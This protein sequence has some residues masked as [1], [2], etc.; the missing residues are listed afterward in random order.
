[1]NERYNIKGRLD[2]VFFVAK[3]GVSITFRE[4]IIEGWRILGGPEPTQEEINR[5]DTLDNKELNLI[6][7]E[8]EWLL[9]K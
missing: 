2:E 5:L 6:I 9:S 3:T 8:L 4:Y 1:M 7:E